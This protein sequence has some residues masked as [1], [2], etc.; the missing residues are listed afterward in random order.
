MIF[1][2]IGKNRT[3]VLRFTLGDAHVTLPG[4]MGISIESITAILRN[5]YSSLTTFFRENYD[6]V[7]A[8]DEVDKK[9]GAKIFS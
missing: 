3:S 4:I 1:A 9:G 2:N 7:I 8:I 6:L 5:T